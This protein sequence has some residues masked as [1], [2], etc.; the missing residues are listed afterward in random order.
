VED[1][2]QRLGRRLGRGA[3]GL[4][5]RTSHPHRLRRRQL[6]SS[7]TAVGAAQFRARAG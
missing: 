5:P 2:R 3:E 7:R 4:A 1:R 6:P